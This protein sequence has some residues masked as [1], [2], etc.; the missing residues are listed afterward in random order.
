MPAASSGG[1]SGLPAQGL[2]GT[3]DPCPLELIA[4]Q[5]CVA[6]VTL[7]ILIEA[8]P[9]YSVL[10]NGRTNGRERVRTEKAAGSIVF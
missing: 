2:P 6:M 1:T 3:R 8:T 4:K 10:L 9:N 5:G 7:A